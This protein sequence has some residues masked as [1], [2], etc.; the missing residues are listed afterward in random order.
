ME[1]TLGAENVSRKLPPTAGKEKKAFNLSA[2][3]KTGKIEGGLRKS[4]RFK[5]DEPGK[6]L[7]TVVTAV[8]NAEDY[9]EETIQSVINQTYDNIEYIVIDG[10][11]SDGTL[12]IIKKYEN[13]IDYWISEKDS[14]LYEALNKGFSAANGTYMSYI[15]AGDYYHKSAID[16]SMDVFKEHNVLWLTGLRI[17]YNEKSQVIRCNLPSRYRRRFIKSGVYGT[18]HYFIQQESTIWHSSLNK[19]VDWNKFAGFKAAGDYYLWHCFSSVTELSIVNSYI[20]GFKYHD[21]QI[22][23]DKKGYLDEIKS[24]AEPFNLLFIPILIFD[25]I[26]WYFPDSIKKKLNGKNLFIYDRDKQKWI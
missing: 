10:G 18:L 2:P 21:S 14:G 22:S 11:S 3:E 4:G 24:F 12:E 13:N 19:S 7:V 16:V 5:K 25:I 17:F 9:I 1:T 26:S 23:S 6:P 15:N 8:Y 20:G